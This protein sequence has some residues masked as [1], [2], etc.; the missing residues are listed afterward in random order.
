M[1]KKYVVELN[2][3]ERRQLEELVSKGKSLAWKIE[4]A[5]ILLKA[6]QGPDGPGW[7]DERIAQAYDVSALTVG[8]LRQRLAEHGLEDAL[9]RRQHEQPLRRKLDGAAEAK[10]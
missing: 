8:R 9:V 1:P 6:D 7:T 10:E 4:H 5:R 3:D 2:T